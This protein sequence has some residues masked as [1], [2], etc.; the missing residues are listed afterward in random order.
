[1]GE[2]VVRWLYRCR[3]QFIQANILGCYESITQYDTKSFHNHESDGGQLDVD[4]YIEDKIPYLPEQDIHF[5]TQL[6]LD[7]K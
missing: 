1:M 2:E 5:H 6:T 3:R 7:G 4:Q